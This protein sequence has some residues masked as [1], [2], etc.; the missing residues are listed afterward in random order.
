M[1]DAYVWGWRSFGANLGPILVTVIAYLALGLLISILWNVAISIGDVGVDWR[2]YR[3]IGVVGGVG[4]YLSSLLLT[5]IVLFV[6]YVLQAAIVRGALAIS[7]GERLELRTMFSFPS[8]GDVLLAALLVSVL[9]SL[10]SLVCGIGAVIVWFFLQFT[11]F[12]VIDVRQNAIDGLRSSARL[13]T[14]NASTM[15]LFTLAALLTLLIGALLCGVGLVVAIP[16]VVL[17]QT[18]LYRRLLGEPVA[19]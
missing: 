14:K 10:G 13:I 16:L 15:V 4:A 1:G 9:T 2:D 18:Y 11:L 19:G 5:L 6:T 7:Y 3:G 12:F 8:L 17:A